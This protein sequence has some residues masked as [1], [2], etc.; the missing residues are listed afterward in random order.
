MCEQQQLQQQTPDPP[1]C[2]H[3]P[4]PLK[5]AILS[6]SFVHCYGRL[7]QRLSRNTC[8]TN[9]KSIVIFYRSVF[10]FSLS[11]THA[12][13]RKYSSH[14][15]TVSALQSH[16][17]F[18]FLT[19]IYFLTLPNLT[20]IDSIILCRSGLISIFTRSE[21]NRRIKVFG[22]NFCRYVRLNGSTAPRVGR[23]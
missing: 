15:F 17:F 21:A 3:P 22:I 6:S 13:K 20:L 19:R 4:Y 1:D 23:E 8:T 18:A 7:I 12:S 2:A 9:W 10:F 5:S 16:F 14:L 11:G